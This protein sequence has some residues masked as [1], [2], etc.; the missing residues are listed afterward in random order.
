MKKIFFLGFSFLLCSCVS[1]VDAR[2][3]AGQVATIG[4]SKPEAPVVCSAMWEDAD[5]RLALAQQ[6]CDKLKKQAVSKKVDWF[7]CS[8]FSPVKEQFVCED[9]K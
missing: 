8:L 9:K 6:E 5:A 4:S 1:Y 3:E 2:R 7:A